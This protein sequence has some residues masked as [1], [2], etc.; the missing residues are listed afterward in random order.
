MHVIFIEP[1]FPAN[2]REFVRALAGIGANVYGIGERPYD[3]LD[4]ETRQR[5]T[6]YQQIESVTN[7]GALE[8]AV[9]DAQSRVWIDRMEATIEAHTLPVARVRERCGIPG[10]SSRTTYLCRD[11]V[12]MK[13]VLRGAGIPVAAS[14][15]VSSMSEARSFAEAVGYPVIIKPRDS[16]GAA[17]T[18][19]ANND[20]ELERAVHASHVADGQQA[21]IEEFIEGHEGIYDTLTV[22][23]DVRHEFIGHYYPGVLEAMRTRWISPQLVST[24]QVE[25]ER[26]GELR[27]LGRRVISALEIPTSATHMEWFFGPKGLKFSEIGCR[28]PGVGQWDSYCAGNEFDLYR[29]WAVAVC[30][31]TVDTRPNRRSA[32]G[33][34]ALRPERDGQISGYSGI[35]KIFEKYGDL[36]VGQH[37]PSPGTHTQ[38]VEAGYMANAWMR[39]RHEDFDTLRGILNEIGETIRVYAR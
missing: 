30:H 12:A 3:W 39:V 29:E 24:N 34:I 31:Y 13:E 35:E 4:D 2:Q 1:A 38:P 14:G 20:A 32:C 21:A 28:P 11:K 37:F 26:Y 18:F 10:V 17:G 7:E 15:A 8:W 9:R 25:A 22:Q 23:G 5:L 36:V 33:I 27:E 16:A 19:R 6:H